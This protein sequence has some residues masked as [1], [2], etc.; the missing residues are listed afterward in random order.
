MIAV[1][2]L[3]ISFSRIKRHSLGFL[4]TANYAFYSGNYLNDMAHGLNLQP[5]FKYCGK[6][7]QT[8]LKNSL[9]PDYYRCVNASP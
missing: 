4:M 9:P 2:T 3:I 7:R 5:V 8:Q 6:I 1:W